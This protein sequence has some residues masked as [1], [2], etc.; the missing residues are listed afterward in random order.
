MFTQQIA[1]KMREDSSSVFVQRNI[2]ILN[3]C[4][5]T[6]CVFSVELAIQ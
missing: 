2:Q 3:I 4:F 1:K 6:G 5:E